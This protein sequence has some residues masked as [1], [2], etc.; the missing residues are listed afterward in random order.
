MRKTDQAPTARPTRTLRQ[1]LLMAVGWVCVA[2]GLAG[3]PLPL[4][5]TTPFLLLA[6]ACFMRSSPALH[7]RMLVDKRLGPYLKQ[8]NADR[9]IPRRARRRAILLVL[10]SFGLSIA[11]VPDSL[12]LRCVLGLLGVCLTLFLSRLRSDDERQVA[13]SR[14]S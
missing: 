5:P 1:V 13:D 11:M 12:L 8:W 10:V 7:E 14:C 2:L 3:I 4:L 6:A 9:S